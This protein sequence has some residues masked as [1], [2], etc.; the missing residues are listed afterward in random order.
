MILQSADGVK[1]VLNTGSSTAALPLGDVLI[2]SARLVGGELPPD[3]AAWV[4]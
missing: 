2:A 3:A 1:C 4:R